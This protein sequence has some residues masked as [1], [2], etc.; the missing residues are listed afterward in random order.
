MVFNHN[1]TRDDPADPPRRP[2][3]RF[4]PPHNGGRSARPR[5]IVPCDLNNNRQEQELP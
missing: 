4:L 3:P 5:R 1:L 2:A